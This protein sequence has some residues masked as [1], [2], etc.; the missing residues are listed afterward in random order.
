M[1][2]LFCIFLHFFLIKVKCW[3]F[4]ALWEE[5]HSQAASSRH[6]ALLELPIIVALQ[7]LMLWQ[8]S[9]LISAYQEVS[10]RVRRQLS[11]RALYHA[12]CSLRGQ[13]LYKR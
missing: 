12:K 2:I 9:S 4:Q 8:P 11:A 6:G 5:K 10:W 13:L 7:L 3:C 1:A